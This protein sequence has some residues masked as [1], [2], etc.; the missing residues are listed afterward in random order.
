MAKLL[1]IFTANLQI[2]TSIYIM[3]C[4]TLNF[5]KYQNVFGQTLPLRTTCAQKG[6]PVSPVKELNNCFSKSI[7]ENVICDQANR[8]EDHMKK[9]KKRTETIC[10][11]M[12]YYL[13]VV[14]YNTNFKN[15][16]LILSFLICK[17]SQFSYTDSETLLSLFKVNSK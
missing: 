15:L 5:L 11:K 12:R 4:E 3:I 17:K 16:I 2:V 13:L 7:P 10:K 1:L 8:A 6:D 9:L 14:T